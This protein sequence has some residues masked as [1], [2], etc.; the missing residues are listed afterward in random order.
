[1]KK[2]ILFLPHNAY[3]TYNMSFALPHLN[4]N[5]DPVFVYLDYYHNEGAKQEME[6]LNLK[7]IPFTHDILEKEEP[8]A[9][10]VMNDWEKNINALIKK[11]KH[12]GI[13]TV[14][15]VE[16]VQD[17]FDTH[18]FHLRIERIRHPYMWVEHPFL[19]GEYDRKFIINKNAFVTGHMRFDSRWNE[20]PKFPSKPLVLINS[21]FTYGRY[22]AQQDMWLQQAFTA[23][24]ELGVDYAVS[25]HHAD[26]KDFSGI[27]VYK[28]P[29]MDALREGSMLISRFSTTLIEAM[30]IG[31][32][33]VY[34]NPHG[35]LMD[36]FQEPMKAFET[37]AN[38]EELKK[39][40][41]KNLKFKGD[42]RNKF[43]AFLNHHVHVEDGKSAA[44][45][46]ASR[47]HQLMDHEKRRNF[48]LTEIEGDLVRKLD[49]MDFNSIDTSL[50]AEKDIE[51][52]RLSNQLGRVK[53]SPSLW[54]LLHH[55]RLLKSLDKLASMLL[56]IKQKLIKS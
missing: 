37:T 48:D 41:N 55:T 7:Y 35:E 36:T 43:S 11:A 29:L 10:V 26:K 16:G 18:Y 34:H 2:K 53:R 23:C 30:V 28:G 51:I 15:I 21:N 40:I 50:L 42:F 24:E 14:G 3:H 54:F 5:I 49:T 12:F 46:T 32:P 13:P 8:D 38:V 45:I 27:N 33:V 31:K 4:A 19:M 47:L 9:L 52:D 20:V 44:E 17:F 39:A 1:M 25:V 6:S 56:K 22:T